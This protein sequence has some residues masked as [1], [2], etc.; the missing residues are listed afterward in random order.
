ME[1]K[2][3]LYYDATTGEILGFYFES[4]HEDNIPTPNKEITPEEHEFYMDNNGKYRLN[5]TTLEYE[6]IP[7]TTITPEPTLEERNR[8]DIDY[9]LVMQ[10]L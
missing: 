4:I 3:Y 10:G 2:I 9:I 7:V 6:E 1:D 5:P 8:A